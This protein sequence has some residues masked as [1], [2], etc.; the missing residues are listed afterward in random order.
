MADGYAVKSDN[1]RS[2]FM[3]KLLMGMTWP[4]YARSLV[5]PFNTIAAII[6][7]VGIP[8]IVM[9][10]VYGL[11]F[12]TH[13]SDVYPWGLYLGWGLFGGVPLS[14]TGF[15]M[16]TAY[17]IFG[18]KAYRPVVRLALLAGFLGYLFA[19]IY[20]LIDLGRPWRIYYPMIIGFGTASV[21]FLV[22]WH[23]ALYLTVQILEFSPAILEWLR[24]RR[25]RKWLE[26]MTIGLTIAGIV[27][28]TLHQSA[29]GAM[30]L[31]APGK[32]HPLWYSSYIHILFLSSSIYAAFSMVIIVSAL[33][34]RF[35]RERCGP[36]FLQNIDRL[37]V[38]LGKAGC[39]A[40]F[41]YF[42]L[43]IISV[44][45]D[46]NW[47]YLNTPYGYWFLVE[48]L[49]FVL[50]PA[51][52]YT[53]GVKTNNPTIVR[54]AAFWAVAGIIMNRINVSIIALNWDLPEHLHHIIPP[55]REAT[56]VLTI[57]TIHILIF[58]W[59]LNRMP[60]LRD[61]PGYEDH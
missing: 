47:H 20:L 54:L 43:K 29:L 44:M 18:F 39:V 61:E 14:A 5:T 9:R 4:E 55:W 36:S 25:V 41:V 60:V 40:M 32:L 59:I 16:G 42:A 7:S 15:V 2:W 17:Y 53:L 37:T 1:F 46:N 24:S 52:V 34:K 51:L 12:V 11:A 56:V 30:Y 31:L 26:M 27:L 6:L 23:V 21:L 13:A 19:V 58:R 33:S 3:D 35:L 38:G 22:A 50:L 8:L 57:V 49:A 10:F 45:H 28:S 48:V